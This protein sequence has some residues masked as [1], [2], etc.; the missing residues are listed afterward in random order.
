MEKEFDCTDIWIQ[1]LSNG[2]VIET[3][4]DSYR[5]PRE[6]FLCMSLEGL[7]QIIKERLTNTVTIK[8]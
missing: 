3:R 6:K 4:Y 7:L 5:I 8:E 2:F 1:R